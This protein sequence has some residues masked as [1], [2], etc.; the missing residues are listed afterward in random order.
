MRYS[1]SG[2]L[3]ELLIE[4]R[5]EYD[6]CQS[7]ESKHA[8]G[9]IAYNPHRAPGTQVDIYIEKPDTTGNEEYQR[10]E[11]EKDKHNS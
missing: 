1:K 6:K 4:K 5:Q 9:N 7:Y 3:I 10:H 2:K 8:E 11:H